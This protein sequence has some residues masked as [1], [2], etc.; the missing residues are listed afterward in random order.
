MHDNVKP[1]VIFL[2]LGAN[3]GN[4]KDNIRDALSIIG[5]EGSVRIE[6]VSSFYLTQ[7]WGK[8]GDDPFVNAVARGLTELNPEQLLVYLKQVE[9]KMGR[10]QT[11]ERMLPREIDLDILLYDDFHIDRSDL[12]IPH[13]EISTREFVLVPLLEIDRDMVHPVSKKSFSSIYD[14][15]KAAG[16]P[17]GGRIIEK[18]YKM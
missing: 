11:S 17:M 14:G 16:F 6:K 10:K 4:K 3:L 5:K 2:G 1:A 15:L 9:L 7:P 8:S 13:P 12:K 18:N